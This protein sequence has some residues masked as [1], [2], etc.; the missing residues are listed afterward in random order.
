M[1][2]V[3]RNARLVLGFPS[4]KPLKRKEIALPGYPFPD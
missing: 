2:K 3:S 1:E 4:H